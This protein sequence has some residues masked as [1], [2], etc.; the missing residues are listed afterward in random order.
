MKKIT[1]YLMALLFL[2]YQAYAQAPVND[3]CSGATTLSVN[4]DLSCTLK[5]SGTLL[6]ATSSNVVSSQGFTPRDDV[7]YAFTATATLHKIRLQNVQSNNT[8]LGMEVFKGSCT[9][10]ISVAFSS[11]Y[12]IPA[13]GLIVGNTYYI[14]IFSLGNPSDS[15]FEICINTP[16]PITNDE[17]SNATVLTVNTDLTCTAAASGHLMGATYNGSDFAANGD[18]WYSFTATAPTN[19]ISLTSYDDNDSRLSF[20]LFSGNCDELVNVSTNT[21][22]LIP[23]TT[24][25]IR[26]FSYSEIPVTANFDICVL[27]PP[28]PSNDDCTN[29]IALSVNADQSCAL[30]TSGTVTGAT[31]SIE[32]SAI[33]GILNDVW[34]TFTATATTH[35][36][37]FLNL[38]GTERNGV[39]YE[40]LEG[41]CGQLISIGSPP[42]GKISSLTVGNTYYIRVFSNPEYISWSFT[43]DICIGIPLPPPVNDECSNAI[44]LAINPGTMCTL[45]SPGTIAEATNSGEGDNTVGAPDDDVWYKFV[46]TATSHTISLL[47]IEGDPAYLIY[48]IM[49]GSC[50][51]QLASLYTGIRQ[52]SKISGL[53]IG[54]TYYIR[55]FSSDQDMNY[56]TSFNLCIALP[57]APPANDNCENAINLTVNP[58]SSCTQTIG[59]TIEGATDSLVNSDSELGIPDDD[60]WYKFVATTTSHKIKLLNVEGEQTDLIL[61]VFQ[62]SC[63]GQLA[64]IS[65]S[66][67][68]EIFISDLTIGNTYYIRVFSSGVN[69][70]GSSSFDI[71]VATG[72]RPQNDNC[73]N[74]IALTVN[75]DLSCTS[76]VT[77]TLTN[78][79]HEA[80]DVFQRADV[81][82]TFVASAY[83]HEI[84]ISPVGYS[85][86]VF[87]YNGDCQTD[88]S[89]ILTLTSRAESVIAHGLT[90]GNTYL[91]KVFSWST[92]SDTFDICI[93]TLAPAPPNDE[94]YDATILEVATNLEAGIVNSTTVGATDF[95]YLPSDPTCTA[96][97]GGDVWFTAIIPPSGELNIQTGTPANSITSP[98][99]SGMEVFSGNCNVLELIECN[100]NISPTDVSSKITLTNRTPGQE[101]YI[102]VWE[103]SNE[104]PRPFTISAWS[105]SL[106]TPEFKTNNFKAY[107]NPV[108]DILNLSYDQIITNVRVY[109][110]L[111]Q[112]ISSKEIND[113]K[114]SIDLSGLPT[115]PYLVQITSDG[116]SKSMTILKQ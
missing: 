93:G 101:I 42:S 76:K 1:F 78:A 24:Y 17:C 12:S 112:T 22:N 37:S 13:S 77:G 100:D 115:G 92:V 26:V 70:A 90:V 6:G 5:T 48:E 105:N 96:Y 111:G 108:Q 19:K 27:T 109:N 104:N 33:T 52:S 35:K 69:T 2:S 39:G 60:V 49:Q 95:T 20:A 89:E 11:N 66:D 44:T 45:K 79:T 25:Y 91:V 53:T 113:K 56:N 74:A 59:G 47:D 50:G 106:T 23:G 40:V 62:G 18:V 63:G 30:K 21:P 80:N 51:G 29:A 65:A 87:S 81:W 84:K 71:C 97:N 88:R 73:S 67:S 14:R 43:F 32:N 8:S 83:Y 64:A 68:Y 99:D 107:P 36:I 55:V 116:I 28:R 110:A 86:Q 61:E 34:Y 72:Q 102:R 54:E 75:T 10:P 114:G 58:N 9:Q 31:R 16:P 41:N 57:P 15:T 3:N 38:E 98:F 46:A 7:W 82:Y 85:C 4:T 103:I 94:C